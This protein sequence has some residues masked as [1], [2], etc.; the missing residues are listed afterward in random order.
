L[1]DLAPTI[2]DRMQ[3]TIPTEMTGTILTK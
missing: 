2:L 1:G 3:L